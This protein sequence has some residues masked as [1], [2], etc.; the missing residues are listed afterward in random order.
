[1]DLLHRSHSG[2]LS[3]QFTRYRVALASIGARTL[4]ASSTLCLIA[5]LAS[6]CTST[7]PNS[8]V[9]LPSHP[10]EICDYQWI[11]HGIRVD[12]EEQ[13]SRLFWQKMVRDRPYLTCDKLG[14]VRGSAGSNPYLG[15]FSLDDDGRIEW[16]KPPKISR[17]VGRRDSSDLEKDFLKALPRINRASVDGDMLTLRGDDGT[18]IE[19]KQTGE[20]PTPAQ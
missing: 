8:L 6:G 18:R 14:F 2:V 5:A 20:L 3:R 7:P 4:G 19:F 11:L 10:G 17:M 12:G 9:S 16:R 13:K 15:K 1:M